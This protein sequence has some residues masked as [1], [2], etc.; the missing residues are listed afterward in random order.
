MPAE[1]SQP[2]RLRNVLEWVAVIAIAVGVALSLRAFVV[3]T[4]FIP[5]DSMWPTLHVGDH[6]LVL[7]AAYDFTS[8]AIGDVIV[9]KAPAAER[10]A[11]DDPSI[12]DLVKRIIATPG[13]TVSSS[14]NTIYVDGRVLPQ[15]WDH[16]RQLGMEITKRTVPKNDYFVLGDNRPSSCDSR[17]WGY[18]P[19]SAIIGRAIFIYWPISRIGTI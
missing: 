18:V 13:D 4:Y 3:Q 1:R 14:G 19:R 7:K 8:P 9:F 16:V 15:P 2:S 17:I 6:I 5:S 11:C 12:T 10:S